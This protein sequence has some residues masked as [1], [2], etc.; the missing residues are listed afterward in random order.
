MTI[1]V[2]IVMTFVAVA[3]VVVMA[4]FAATIV[5]VDPMIV[6]HMTGNPDHLVVAIPIAV[7][8]AMIG[9]VAHLNF[10]AIRA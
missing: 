1:A 5:A 6:R 4:V 2:V 9:P 7:A 10:Y 3:I 8:M